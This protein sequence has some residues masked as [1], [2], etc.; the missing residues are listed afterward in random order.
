[1]QPAI[2]GGD[3]SNSNG[4]LELADGM[5]V[6][7]KEDFADESNKRVVVTNAERVAACQNNEWVNVSACDHTAQNSDAADAVTTYT[8]D[9]DVYHTKHCR[10]CNVTIQ[11]QH[12]DSPCA[13]GQENQ[14]MLYLMVPDIANNTYGI[15][16]QRKVG[17][18]MKFTLPTCPIVPDGY[19]FLGWE[20][21]PDPDDIGGYAAVTGQDIKDPFEVVEVYAGQQDANFYARYIYDFFTDWTWAADGSSA[22]LTLSHDVLGDDDVTLSSTGDDPKVTIT[23]TVAKDDDDNVVGTRYTA[24]CTYTLNNYIYTFTDY[25]DVMVSQPE[26]AANLTLSETADNTD[27]LGDV[28]GE[29]ANLSGR[30]LYK[31][32][33]WNTLCLPFD[34]VLEGSPLEGATLKTLASSDYDA[35]NGTLTLTFADATAIEGGRPYLVKWTTTG[36]DITDPVFNSVTINGTMGGCAGSMYV[37]FMGTFSPVTLAANDKSMLYV[38]ADNTLYYPSAALTIG[39]CRDGETTSLNEEL[40]VKN[41]EFAT[42]QWYTLDGRKLS[43]KPRQKGVYINNGKKVVM[44]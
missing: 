18:G 35:D 33:S 32:G 37:D 29:Q 31:D 7:A 12:S 6:K 2:G 1:L 28:L 39:S 38:G 16:H 15:G 25:K 40:R 3:D 17:T 8:I 42:A 11:E 10:Y 13:C 43:G 4:T 5:K 27:A 26:E 20:M 41:E 23:S 24:T 14:I 30:T 36:A 44:K 21:N 22:S 9:D 34:L 19:T